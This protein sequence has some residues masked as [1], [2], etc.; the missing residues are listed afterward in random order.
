MKCIRCILIL[1]SFFVEESVSSQIL[2]NNILPD[3]IVINRKGF[4]DSLFASEVISKY[5]ATLE[6]GFRQVGL[7]RFII[8][9]VRTKDDLWSRRKYKHAFII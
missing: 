5:Y 1:L 3:V 6:K 7:P 8:S 2:K 4:V 9:G